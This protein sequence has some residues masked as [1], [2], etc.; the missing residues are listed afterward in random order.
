MTKEIELKSGYYWYKIT[1][2]GV[3]SL[4]VV[5]FADW[6]PVQVVNS[7]GDLIYVRFIGNFNP[8]VPYELMKGKFIPIKPP[9]NEYQ[10][11]T[12]WWSTIKTLYKISMGKCKEE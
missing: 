2:E 9:T 4:G 6:E 3:K 1:A 12:S 11:E 5:S 10:F 8:L 7:G